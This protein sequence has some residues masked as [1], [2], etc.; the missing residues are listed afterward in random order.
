MKA[1][2]LAAGLGTRL[3]PLTDNMPK[4]LVPVGPEGKPMLLNLVERLKVAGIDE[5]VINV[6]HFAPMI[7]DFV[8]SQNNFGIKVEFSDESGELLDTGGGILYA[9]HLLENDTFLVHNVDIASN[10]DIRSFIKR[11]DDGECLSQLVVSDRPSSRK[12]LFD[13]NLRLTGWK[14]LKTGEIRGTQTTDGR[15]LA[16]SGIHLLSP[17]IYKAFDEYP[18]FAGKFSITDFY[19]ATCGRFTYRAYI[20]DGLCVT[21]LGKPEAISRSL[22]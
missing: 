21:D 18:G 12:L 10:L 16:F 4:A 11:G 15:E 2:I 3:R 7:V 19:I 14:N 8:R 13:S 6:H 22:Q 1:L 5:V 9:R 20:Q 17:D